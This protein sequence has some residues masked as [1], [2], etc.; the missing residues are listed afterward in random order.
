M[1]FSNLK[2]GKDYKDCMKT[3]VIAIMN[4]EYFKEGDFHEIA[5]IKRNTENIPLTDK[6]ELH[7]IQLP[8]FR[9]KCKKLS[10]GIDYWLALIMNF[11][12]EEVKKM[13]KEKKALQKAIDETEYLTGEEA[14]KRWA[15]LRLKAEIDENTAYSNGLEQ[16][17]LAIA[18]KM[19]E[20]KADIEFIKTCTGLTEE[21]I[22][23]LKEK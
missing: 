4:F 9:K 7:Y 10:S 6:M 3:I 8:K 12:M 13:A 21:E 20:Q 18:K 22:N 17:K 5:T 2:R 1:Y 19:L 16:G 23:K 15:Y 11:E 14:E